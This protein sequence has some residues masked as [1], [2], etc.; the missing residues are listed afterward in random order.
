[1]ARIITLFAVLVLML[2]VAS[3]ADAT[4]YSYRIDGYI[5]QWGQS[6]SGPGQL[7]GAFDI[8]LSPTGNIYVSEYYGH[9]V[10]V[11]DSDYN[12]LTSFGGY[13]GGMGT[14]NHVF[15]LAIDRSGWVYVCD[16]MN[17]LIQ[18]FEPV[19]SDSGLTMPSATSSACQHILGAFPSTR[20]RS[21]F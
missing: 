7:N 5:E 21:C 19:Q 4:G 13:G 9:R 8:A 12:Y 18:V 10:S 1:M 6:G 17:W 16:D 20:A 14:F 15:G 3:G 11:F 2:G